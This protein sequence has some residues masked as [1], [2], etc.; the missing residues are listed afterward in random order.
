LPV[1]LAASESVFGGSRFHA[2]GGG[3]RMPAIL[4][5]RRERRVPARWTIFVQSPKPADGAGL[6]EL[7]K[8]FST[9]TVDILP[10]LGRCGKNGACAGKTV[11]IGSLCREAWGS[12]AHGHACFR[13]VDGEA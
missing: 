11:P 7:C 1:F 12:S 3:S 4:R 5:G 10:G 2:G 8:E 6:A 9:G 13:Q